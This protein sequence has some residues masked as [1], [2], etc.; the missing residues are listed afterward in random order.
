VGD[1][2]EGVGSV[3]DDGNSAEDWSKVGIVGA[4]E[5][6]V[7]AEG[8]LEWVPGTG[9]KFETCEQGWIDDGDVGTAVGDAVNGL[10]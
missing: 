1:R 9:L 8:D 6:T 4:P 5:F 3:I 7:V 10:T 2:D